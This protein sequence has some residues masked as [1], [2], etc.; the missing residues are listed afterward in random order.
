MDQ[1]SSPLSI[2]LSA[3]I[4]AG[5]FAGW[6]CD[7]MAERGMTTRSLAMRSGID[8]GT[9]SRVMRGEQDPRLTTAVA[10]LR[11]LGKQPLHLAR[12]SA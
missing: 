6:L 1:Q 4:L 10:L 5:D 3:R 7:A 12:R 2:P 11:V 9:I 8:H